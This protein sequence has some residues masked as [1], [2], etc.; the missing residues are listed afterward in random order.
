M[1]S[2]IIANQGMTILGFGICGQAKIGNF[3]F[4]QIIGP[5]P[6]FG[7]IYGDHQA[8]GVYWVDKKMPNDYC[9]NGKH[10]TWKVQDD[11]I[12]LFVTERGVFIK[13]YDWPLTT[14]QKYVSSSTSYSQLHYDNRKKLKLKIT[15]RESAIDRAALNQKFLATTERN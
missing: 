7:A 13:W 1:N 15:K 4:G 14:M 9:T 5:P 11:G 12:Y 8:G 6:C 3:I 2:I 10:C